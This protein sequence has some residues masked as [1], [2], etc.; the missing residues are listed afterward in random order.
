MAAFIGANIN[1]F[2][3][4]GGVSFDP[5]NNIPDLNGK[6]FLITGGNGGLGK[7]TI[8]QLAKHNPA[9]IFMG[10]RSGPKAEEAID[11]IKKSISKDVDIEW[12][13]MDLT[14]VESIKKG[15]GTFLSS[16]SRL[17]VLIL[18]AGVMSLPPGETE[19]GHEIQFGTNHTG[20]FLLLKLLLP[21][22]LK[23]AEEPNSDVRVVTVSSVGHTLAPSFETLL[24]QED[25]KNVNTHVRYGASKAAN[26]IFAAELSRR[27]PSITSVSVHPGVILTGLYSSVS[28]RYAFGGLG[29][30][31]VGIFG[32]Q[33]PKGAH[34][35]LWAAAGARKEELANGNYYVPVGNHKINNKFA[36][37]E[38]MGRRLWEWS[39]AELKKFGALS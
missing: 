1:P 8:L 34:N 14:S 7:E 29:T 35:Q 13:P 26:I 23:T 27:Y 33:I 21:T 6:V 9:K 31:M 5:D 22:I 36:K 10:A 3:Y 25:L 4:I 16:S 20:H 17:D 32:T 30:K 38:T 11:N 39:E 19:M 12:L 24:N 28:Q 37:D 15:A 18:N 2:N